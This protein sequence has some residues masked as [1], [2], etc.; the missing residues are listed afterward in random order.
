MVLDPGR[1]GGANRRVVMMARRRDALFHNLFIRTLGYH[2][3]VLVAK[4]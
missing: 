4:Y 3:D 2:N 1:G